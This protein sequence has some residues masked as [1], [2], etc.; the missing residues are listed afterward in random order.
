MRRFGQ[1][2]VS[3]Y[4]RELPR[5]VREHG[6][7][8]LLACLL[9][10]VGA[11]VGYRAGLHAGMGGALE[12][13]DRS[14]ETRWYDSFLPSSAETF[15]GH[16]WVRF[17]TRNTFAAV[18]WSLLGFATL[19]L[20]AAFI[21]WRSGRWIGYAIALNCGVAHQASG[22]G[23]LGVTA[24]VLLPH[25]ILEIPALLFAW[26]LAL[27]GGL[28]WVWPL[29]GLRRWASVKRML[30]QFSL[31]LAAVIPLLF[32]A[33]LLETYA[34]PVFAKRYLLGIGTYKT[35]A[36]ERVVGHPF[37]VQHSSWSPRGDRIAV[38][39]WARTL[40]VKTLRDG[41]RPVVICRY[42]EGADFSPPSWSPDGK[43]IVLARSDP[44]DENNK[45]NGLVFVDVSSHRL[46]VVRGGPKGIYW[47][48]A[49]SPGGTGIAAVVSAR[50]ADGRRNANL[51]VFDLGSGAWKQVTP[52]SWP[53]G[54]DLFAN[55]SWSPDAHR[56]AFVRKAREGKGPRSSDAEEDTRLDLC[57]V[58]L[59]TSEVREVTRVGWGS[60]LAW[61]PDGKWIA[62]SA[63]RPTL[64]GGEEDRFGAGPIMAGVGLARADGSARFDGLVHADLS[65]SLSW[66]PDGKELA[67]QRWGTCIIGAPRILAGG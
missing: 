56:V 33:A 6:Y 22:A 37:A 21:V 5:T 41:S 45:K 40:S 32:A 63:G 20:N 10:V 47:Q 46:E 51:W 26:G 53:T 59:D 11:A 50:R 42:E 67:Y 48:A 65:S 66:S 36:H 31:S 60:S 55:P 14:S 28:A 39:D 43:H 3:V 15:S 44:Q 24:G 13:W 8:L 16:G 23:P 1:S 12:F 34:N 38:V 7:V 54:L 52:F 4:A 29:R 18:W 25:A 27:R 17:F 61:S 35:M 58:S 62:F 9:Y 64:G 19:G 49:W 57:V 30:R 2:L